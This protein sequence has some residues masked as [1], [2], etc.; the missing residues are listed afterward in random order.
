L[1][2]AYPDDLPRFLALCERVPRWDR[3]FDLAELHG[4]AGIL[5]RALRASGFVLPAGDRA[6]IDRRVAA[7]RLIQK[8]QNQGM[9]LVLSALDQ[10]GFPVVVLKGPV[11][12]ERL[13]GDPASRFSFDL[14]LL[15]GSK[16]LEGV[17]GA[18]E[19]VGFQAQGGPTGQYDRAHTHNITFSRAD[20]PLV[21]V[22]FHLLVEFG[23]T[24][25]A[26]DFLAHSLPYETAD[27]TRCRV[28]MPED[29]LFYLLLHAVHHE[30]GRFCW[31]Y[32]IATLLRLRPNLDWDRV[33][34]RAE[35]YRV[36][37]SIHYTR[38][39]L[40][41]RLG[42]ERLQERGPFSRQARQALAS[43]LLRLY[44]LFAPS[45]STGTLINLFFKAVLC[46]QLSASV[47]FL[48]HNLWR[49]TRRRL[50]CSLRGLVPAEWAG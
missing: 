3:C 2:L 44:H 39:V 15:I 31:V 37:E 40:R 41:H 35:E 9:S 12:G 28:L 48:G 10:A 14:D 17:S 46:D 25:P 38:E 26:D 34:R 7:G 50:Y 4:V 42:R 30:F 13:Y 36:R 47:G 33:A 24:I 16:D 20:F 19:Q 27:G 29:E 49:I 23:V 6:L 1:L 21:E 8:C 18:L 5:H 22:H 32:D 43:Q 45:S 11:L